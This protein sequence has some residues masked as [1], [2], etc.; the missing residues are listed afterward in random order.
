MRISQSSPTKTQ[1]ATNM[2]SKFL[3]IQEDALPRPVIIGLGFLAFFG[4]SAAFAYI[5]KNIF[6]YDDWIVFYSATLEFLQGLSPFDKLFH[7]SYYYNPPWVTLAL[8]PMAITGF[9]FGAG[10]LASAT[11]FATLALCRRYEISLIKTTL[12][13]TSPIIYYIILHGQID[14]Y[15]LAGVLLP[16][17][18]W[19]LVALAKPQTALM[20]GLKALEKEHIKKAL[21]V[22]GAI[23]LLS[24][25]V[26]G[27]W[28]LDVIDKEV[29]IQ[30]YHNFW[31]TTWPWN[32]IVG[33]I[34]V[35]YWFKTKDERF[36][37]SAS[38]FFSPYAGMNS[39]LG[40]WI[41]LHTKLK[42]W[43]A[44]ILFIVAWVLGLMTVI[45]DPMNP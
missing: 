7:F 26:Y 17:S 37:L 5:P 42:D 2:K 23:F 16:V 38:P 45:I 19:P 18:F 13:L 31:R 40:L 15:V 22:S 14:G 3:Q 27:L 39:F 36:L 8:A 6:L 35:I 43:Q 33:I 24:L 21:I 11:I 4:L 32:T 20:L 44:V 9:R 34:L 28:P 41:A 29:P 12:V 10:M 1:H 25:A 30:A